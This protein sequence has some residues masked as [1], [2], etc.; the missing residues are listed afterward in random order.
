MNL[1]QP[2]CNL[3]VCIYISQY[4]MSVGAASGLPSLSA[5][6]SMPLYGELLHNTSAT[7]FQETSLVNSNG[8]HASNS[9]AR[10]S[11][12]QI[13]CCILF[14]ERLL[15]WFFHFLLL[16]SKLIKLIVS[17]IVI[18]TQISNTKVEKKSGLVIGYQYFS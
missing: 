7:S 13:F 15:L 17:T 6:P 3:R 16:L 2:C 1:Q 18:F 12:V 11:F 14:H 9:E 4:L 8:R 10:I 5:A